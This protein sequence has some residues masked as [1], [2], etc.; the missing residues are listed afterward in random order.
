MSMKQHLKKHHSVNPKAMKTGG[1]PVSPK[2]GNKTR[3][4]GAAVKGTKHSSKMG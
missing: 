4:T 3:G 2:K 1:L